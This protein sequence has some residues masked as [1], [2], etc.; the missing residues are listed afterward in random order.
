MGTRVKHGMIALF[1]CAFG[2]GS[3]V[4]LQEASGPSIGS[5][6]SPAGMVL[7]ITFPEA[8]ADGKR[9]KG[10]KGS[11][12]L[13]PAQ[14]KF[15][16]KRRREED[17]KRRREEAKKNPVKRKVLRDGDSDTSNCVYDS[18]ASTSGSSDIYNCGGNYYR[19]SKKDGVWTYEAVK[20]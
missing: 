1:G 17:E 5:A 14:R 15:D 3:S 7:R 10:S 8:R 2:F 18:Y 4:T 9:S 19:R 11:R 20:P 12:N 13:S 6:P 16:E